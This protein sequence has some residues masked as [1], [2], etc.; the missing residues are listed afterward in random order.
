MNTP[1]PESEETVMPKMGVD[2]VLWE[3]FRQNYHLDNSNAAVHTAIVRYSPLT[4]RLAEVLA[5][6]VGLERLG[7]IDERALVEVLNH[8]GTYEEDTGR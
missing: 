5:P 6:L 1:E 4:F 2:E 7:L 3:C 8:A